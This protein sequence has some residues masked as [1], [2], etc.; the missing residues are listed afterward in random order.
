MYVDTHDNYIKYSSRTSSSTILNLSRLW[1]LKQVY[2]NP[3][4]NQ[5][6]KSKQK[7]KVKNE[8]EKHVFIQRLKLLLEEKLKT[9]LK[10]NKPRMKE[11]LSNG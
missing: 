8:S 2:H 4:S 6:K 5:E 7:D 9:V 3:Q 11:Q 10:E 1:K